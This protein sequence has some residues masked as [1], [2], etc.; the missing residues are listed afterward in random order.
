MHTVIVCL[1]AKLE[2]INDLK[3]QLQKIAELSRQEPSNC[4]YHINQD[5]NNPAVFI[6]YENWVNKEEHAKQF[7]KEYIIEFTKHAEAWLAKP[8]QVTIASSCE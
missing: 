5:M 6:L 1:E 2:Y 7:D 4:L 3:S 8:Y